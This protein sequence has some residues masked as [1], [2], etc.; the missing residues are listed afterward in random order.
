MGAA[1]RAGA[2]ADVEGDELGG[3]SSSSSVGEEIGSSLGDSEARWLSCASGELSLMELKMSVVTMRRKQRAKSCHSRCRRQSRP[4][5]RPS[6]LV[7][8]ASGPMSALSCRP[9]VE[10]SAGRAGVLDKQERRHPGPSFLYQLWSAQLQITALDH[11]ISACIYRNLSLLS[12]PE[13]V[14]R[15]T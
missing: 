4:T 15:G 11:S 14:S 13:P 10:S 8:R 9:A 5:R 3:G 2:L 6:P 7:A 1:R 12:E